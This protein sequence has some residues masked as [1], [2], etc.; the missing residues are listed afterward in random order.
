M[1]HRKSGRKLDRTGSHRK[2]LYRNL[3]LSL[4][5][6]ER[7]RTTPPKAKEAR[8]LAEKAITLDKEGSIASRRRVF[9]MLRDREIV[10]KLFDDIAPRYA[11]R[12]GG[13]T[14]ILHLDETRLGDNAPQVIFELVKEDEKAAKKREKK[15]KVAAKPQVEQKAPEKPEP[16][17]KKQ[18]KRA[19]QAEEK[20]P[21]QDKQK[22]SGQGE[23]STKT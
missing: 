8:R 11:D 4:F 10:N 3:T 23:S 20:P 15:P 6:H 9:A 22:E 2:A 19:R 14:R 18:E 7:I 17:E 5:I 21:G 16:E 13:Y 1:R 12:N